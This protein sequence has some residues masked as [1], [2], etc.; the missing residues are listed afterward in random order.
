MCAGRRPYS[1]IKTVALAL[2]FSLFFLLFISLGTWQVRRLHWK[3]DLIERVNQRVHASPVAAPACARTQ[4]VTAQTDEYRHVSLTGYFL[5][6]LNTLVQAS[7]ELGSGFWVMSPFQTNDHCIVYV[8]RGFIPGRLASEYQQRTS[9]AAEPGRVTEPVPNIITISGLLR[10]SEPRGGFLR[11]NDPAQE[12]WY[13]RDINA[14]AKSHSLHQVA[15]YFV[16]VDAGPHLEHPQRAGD[17]SQFPVGGLTVISFPNNHLVYALVWYVLALMVGG[18]S[19]F[20]FKDG[21]F[22]RRSH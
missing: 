6:Q 20:V 1:R 10:M 2:F 4:A 9:S 18:A 14:I 17:Q 16:D 3:L 13:S 11:R 5:P 12:R 7:T 19:Y 8:N 15:S 22:W 21:N